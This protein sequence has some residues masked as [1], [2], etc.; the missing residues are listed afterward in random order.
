MSPEPPRRLEPDEGFERMDE[1]RM[2]NVVSYLLSGVVMFAG[3]GALLDSW[4]GTTWMVAVG[5]L[6]GM[7]VSLYLVWFRYGRS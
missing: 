4:L 5:V 2:W 3:L 7:G 1:S 6:G